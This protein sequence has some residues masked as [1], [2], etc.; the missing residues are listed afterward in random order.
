MNFKGV[1]TFGENFGKFI[2]NY[3]NLMFTNVNLVGQ[4]CM[5]ENEVSIQV[6]HMA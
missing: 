1:Q 6:A 4:S 2:K 3:L 5:Q